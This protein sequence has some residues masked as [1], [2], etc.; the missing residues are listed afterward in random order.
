MGRSTGSSASTV[1]PFS[2]RFSTPTFRFANAGM[3]FETGSSRESLPSSTSIMAATAALG[4]PTA[5]ATIRSA[6]TATQHR[7][8]KPS[9]LHGFIDQLLYGLLN[10]LALRGR[11]LQQH[12]KHILLAVDH[13]IA[14]AGAIPFQLP[15]RSRR[16]RLGVA[17][18]GANRKPKPEAE[19]I[20]GKIEVVAPDAGTRAYMIRGHQFE[21]LGT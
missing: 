2:S 8:V 19:A 14:A 15:Q 12:K 4:H 1:L 21:G 5:N 13:E 9:V 17:G 7:R 20:A 18:I 16:R 6:S 11:L 3:Y 10:A